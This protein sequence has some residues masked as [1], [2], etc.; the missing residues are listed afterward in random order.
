MGEVSSEFNGGRFGI[1]FWFRRTED[2]LSWSSNLVSNVM[3]SLGDEN[4]SVLEIGTK[5]SA[6][7]L[8]LATAVKDEQI[9]IGT[10]VKDD[11]WHFLSLSYDE[12]ASMM[13]N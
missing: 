3:V 8:F 5:G 12:N 10:E 4:G 13:L 7:D 9:T 11:R 6:L 2:S 1:S